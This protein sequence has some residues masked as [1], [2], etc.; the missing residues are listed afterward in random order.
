MTY[1]FFSYGS[2]TSTKDQIP[3][4]IE[5]ATRTQLDTVHADPKWQT[6]WSSEHLADPTIDKYAVT[7][8]DGELIALGAYQV[9]DRKTHV[10][11]VYAA[12]P[13]LIPAIP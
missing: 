12:P 9:Q 10:I 7:T 8:E 4:Q 13:N 5:L 2:L 3:V 11:I 6:D 1:G